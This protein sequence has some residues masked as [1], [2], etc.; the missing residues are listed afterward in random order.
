MIFKDNAP[1]YW[2]K[3]LPVIPLHRWDAVDT[4]GKKLGKAPM[5]AAWQLYNNSM[6]TPQ[7][8]A[9]WLSQFPDNNIGLPLGAQSHCIALDI[10]S[11]VES[12][13]ALIDSL[14]PQ[15]PW[16]RVGKHGKVLMFKFN[17]E[18]TF[19]IKDVT[20]RTI[21]ELLSSKTQVVLPPSIHPDTKNPYISNCNL[22]DVVDRLPILPKNLEETLRN[23]LHDKLGIDLHLSGWTRTIDYVSVGS[24]D[25]KMTSVAG[26]YAHSVLRGECSLK[27]AIDMMRTWCA[28]QV[29]KVAGDEIDAD[30]GVRNLVKFM[31]A[32][33][34]G[35]KKRVL[36][37]GWDDDL[38]D[39]EKKSLNIDVDE[40]CLS[41]DFAK[42]NKYLCDTIAS[43][44]GNS[45]ERND[46]IE[47]AV[48]K[49]ARSKTLSSIEEE[50]CIKHIATC[51]QNVSVAMLRKRIL[52]LRSEGILGNNHTEIAKAV[53][54]EINDRIPNYENTD[55]DDEYASLRHYQS[56]IWSWAGSNW[57]KVEDSDVLKVIA[58]EYG[59]LPAA[60]KSQDHKG[61]LQVMKTLLKSDLCETVTKGVN[62][63]NG[64]VDVFGQLHP[65]SRKYGCTYTLPYSYK[66]ELADLDK[67][68]KFLRYLR[69]VWGKEPDF[70]QRVTTLRQVMAST[71]FGLGPSF[72]RAILL[73]G[74]GGSGKTQLLTIMRRLLPAEIISVVNPYDFSDKFKVTE[75]SKSVLNICGELRE[76]GYLAGDLFK[77]II[78]GTPMQGQYKNSQIF[79]FMPKA[80]HWFAGNVLPRTKDTSEGFSR[81]WVIFTFNRIIPKSEKIRDLGDIIAAEER[82]AITAWCIGAMAE[83][84]SAADYTL[85]PSHYKTVDD[86]I[87]SNDSIF[88]Y[89]T[90]EAEGPRMLDGATTDLRKIYEAYK[91]FCYGPAGAKPVGVR[92]FLMRLNE[93]G[94]IFGFTVN[95][96]EVRGLT[97]EKGE[98]KIVSRVV[99]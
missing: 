98:G 37:K 76:D 50:Q 45:L 10:D 28:T 52:E 16:V 93:L 17:G 80:T 22:Y 32:D 60:R 41:W 86:M 96:S 48:D 20:G 99:K 7:E 4:A 21:C 53:L 1:K 81:R 55:T 78:D 75:L 6:P 71:M 33:V 66:P 54:H 39:E 65:H 9:S 79:N 72:N 67:A 2:E 38:T 51:C 3:G 84:Q 64:F 47:F 83:L 8:Q 14:V 91:T 46:M 25:V 56:G 12:E 82:E 97:L 29:E 85:P 94:I 61:I 15:S 5:P 49:I 90:S 43:T 44:A 42:L 58:A 40:N 88:F 31:M 23:A 19:R 70:R 24:R 13:I 18:Q 77:Q 69:S 35:P 87:A 27:Q 89:L 30:K 74:I 34:Y 26:L 36:P 95:N 57:E 59:D 92:R 63:A 68:P 73:Y 11:E 62:F